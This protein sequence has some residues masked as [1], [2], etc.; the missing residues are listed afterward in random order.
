MLALLRY[1]IECRMGAGLHVAA[2]RWQLLPV[3]PLHSL[4]IKGFMSAAVI[5]FPAAQGV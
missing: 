3:T 1:S 2:L 5:C 4:I